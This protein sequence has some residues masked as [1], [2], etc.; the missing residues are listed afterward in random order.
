MNG[1]PKWI[2]RTLIAKKLK[3]INTA[4]NKNQLTNES[5]E[6]VD[7]IWI[8]L[9]YLG[10]QG[11]QLLLSL[12][13][14]IT[15]CLTKKVKFKVTQSTQKLCF[16]TT[17]KDKTNKL[18]KSYVVYQFCCSGCNSKYIGKTERNLCVRL[19]EHATDNGSSV[20]NHISDCANYQYIKNLHCIGNKSFDAYTY[21]INSIQENTNI[22]LIQ[23]ETGIN[24]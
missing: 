4:N 17:I 13:R 7:V 21:D 5:N 18:M 11:D 3:N 16:Y 23:L 15:R 20:F 10:T 8:H 22:T 14:K 9:P 1:F 6:N 12:K 24:Y 2:G 19:E